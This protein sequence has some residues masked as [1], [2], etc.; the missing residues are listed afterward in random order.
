MFI[1]QV[2]VFVKS[3]DGGDGCVSF[4]REKFVPRGGPDG[5]DGG[6][7][8]DVVFEVSPQMATLI[9][10]R[11]QQR[12][13]VKRGEHGGRKKS[14]G[15]H[16]PDLLIPV[17]RGT[18][19]RDA[20]TSEL[21]AD[22]THPGQRVIAVRGGRGGRGNT[23]FKSATRQAPQMAEP[24]QKGE[25]RWLQLELKLLADVGLVGLPNA[26]KS[27][28]IST[29]SSA[30]PKIADYPFTTLEPNLGV[31]TVERSRGRNTQFTVADIPGLIAGAHEGKGLGIKFLKHVE[32][33]SLLLHLV[34]VSEPASEDPV[35]DL[36]VI[37]EELRLYHHGL[38]GKPFMVAATKIDIAGEG[39]RTEVLRRY[40]GK[41]E[42]PFFEVSSATGKGM[43][44]LKASLV[45]GVEGLRKQSQV[46]DPTTVSGGNARENRDDT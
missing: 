16:T 34:D 9:D 18:V 4:R 6:K 1:D 28:L 14:F 17:P 41:K 19:I 31:V 35:E 22:L 32:R 33:T 44:D 5:G 27:T 46:L 20:E 23:H 15:K 38:P 21:V 3:G 10:L 24:G 26:G 11:Y 7:G 2:K 39:L 30:H 42:I 45:K 43:D 12:Y 29:L 25:E 8:G 40:C 13:I 36:E 37:R